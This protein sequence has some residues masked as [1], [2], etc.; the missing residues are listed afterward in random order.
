MLATPLFLPA[1]ELR[2]VSPLENQANGSLAVSEVVANLVAGNAERR[3]SF[4]ELHRTAH[5]SIGLSRTSWKLAV[6][7]GRQGYLS[8]SVDK[9]IY[10]HL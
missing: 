4:A 8:S 10:C 5:L 2:A 9:E 6:R 1:Q 3:Q 7:N